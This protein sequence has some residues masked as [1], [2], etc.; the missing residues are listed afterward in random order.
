MR[1]Y[2]RGSG[3]LSTHVSIDDVIEKL[4]ALSDGH[5]PQLVGEPLLLG[6]MAGFASKIALINLKW[7]TERLDLPSRVVL[8]VPTMISHIEGLEQMKKEGKIE[9]EAVDLNALQDTESL[10]KKVHNVEMDFYTRIQNMEKRDLSLLKFY[11][12]R[13]FDEENSSKGFLLLEYRENL[14]QLSCC[15]F[16]DEPT[17]L[18]IL[19]N[20]A[21]LHSIQKFYSEEEQKIKSRGYLSEI[22]KPMLVSDM[23]LKLMEILKNFTKDEELVEKVRKEVERMTTEEEIAAL[24]S[25]S[26]K[27]G[28]KRVPVHG[29]GWQ[30][31]MLFRQ[32]SEE[33]VQLDALI[34]FQTLHYGN[35]GAELAKAFCSLLDKGHMTEVREKYLQIYYGFLEDEVQGEMPF[36]LEQLRESCRRFLPLLAYLSACQKAAL[37][38]VQLQKKEPHLRESF[39][40]QVLNNVRT[41][42]HFCTD[43]SFSSF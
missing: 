31:N 16:I 15:D 24:D 14:I 29:D 18:Q 20:F 30:C 36:S 12:G 23:T 1:L 28:M 3:V 39:R 17:F 34:D 43:P 7:P 19:R 41:L 11:G 37:V 8:K 6:E 32:N 4:A 2:E 10:Y 35:A 42:L 9:G 5:R 40:E 25:T 21:A 26:E 22:Y 27:L 33:I 38:D 13:L